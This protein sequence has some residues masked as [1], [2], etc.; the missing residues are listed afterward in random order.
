MRDKLK[1]NRQKLGYTHER[2]SQLTG[3]ERTKYTRIENGSIKKVSLDDAFRISRAL[4]ST[5]EEIFLPIDVYQ[6]HAD[7]NQ[8]STGTEGR[9]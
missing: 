8:A 4:N 9:R 5:I 2:M 7:G 6:V 3:I 1:E